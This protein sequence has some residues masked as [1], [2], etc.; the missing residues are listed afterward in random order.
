[1]KGSGYEKDFEIVYGKKTVTHVFSGKAI[2]RALRFLIDHCLKSVQIQRFFWSVF[3]YIRTEF[4]DLRSYLRIQCEY[5]KIRTR[6]NS[7]FG[8]FSRSGWCSS[9]DYLVSIY[10][11]SV[12]RSNRWFWWKGYWGDYWSK[13]C[14]CKILSN[15]CCSH[16]HDPTFLLLLFGVLGHF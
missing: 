11:V 5:W 9:S 14:K 12:A 6:K 7:L 10:Q 3:S 8:Y 2:S 1:M 15:L 4:E 13:F 16:I